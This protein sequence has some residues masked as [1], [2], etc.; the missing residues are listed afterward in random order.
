MSLFLMVLIRGHN[1]ILPYKKHFLTKV[2][3]LKL[4]ASP[5]LSSSLLFSWTEPKR[6]TWMPWALFSFRW[7]NYTLAFSCLELTFH[8]YL[9]SRVL[10]FTFLIPSD[11]SSS[12]FTLMLHLSFNCLPGGDPLLQANLYL[13]NDSWMKESLPPT[14]QSVIPV[15]QP[16]S[17]LFLFLTPSL[18]L[19]VWITSLSHSWNRREGIWFLTRVVV[20]DPSQVCLDPLLLHLVHV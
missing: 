12:S 14:Q 8:L 3:F 15:T 6:T 9:F 19:I 4:F 10:D 18:V 7:I 2:F 13:E 11:K 1:H 16:V 5:L 20:S 17:F